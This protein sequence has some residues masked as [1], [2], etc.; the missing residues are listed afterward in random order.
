[1]RT[2]AIFQPASPSDLVAFVARCPLAQIVSA[3]DCNYEATPVPLV[4]DVDT[5]G[6]SSGSL[7]TSLEPT[8]K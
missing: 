8:R 1:M 4:A 3:S 6:R 5:A 7:A 2:A